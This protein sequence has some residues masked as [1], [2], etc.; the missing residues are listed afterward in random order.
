LFS[1]GPVTGAFPRGALAYLRVYRGRHN[2]AN[3]IAISSP[4][5]DRA[6]LLLFPGRSAVI[7]TEDDKG[8]IHAKR[9][10]PGPESDEK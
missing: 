10:E 1:R 2:N 6:D 9:P 3:L 4:S 7:V 5:P 8:A